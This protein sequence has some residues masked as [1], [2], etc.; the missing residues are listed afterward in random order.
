MARLVQL[1]RPFHP[2]SPRGSVAIFIIVGHPRLY[3]TWMTHDHWKA[4]EF[5][6]ANRCK[7]D[8]SLLPRWWFPRLAH[9]VSVM[10]RGKAARELFPEG[11]R[12][13]A[14]DG[15]GGPGCRIRSALSAGGH[16]SGRAPVQWW[17]LERK[18]EKG[19]LGCRRA[20]GSGWGRRAAAG[21]RVA[22]RLWC[23]LGRG[24][25]LS[26]LP[27]WGRPV[28]CLGATRPLDVALCA[29]GTR[30]FWPCV[31]PGHI[32]SGLVCPRARI[33]PA[34]SAGGVSVSQIVGG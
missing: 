28:M 11:Q 1:I 21:V 29:T 2:A 5:G 16:G 14:G 23:R 6:A 9:D 15:C 17:P 30:P 8:V 32:R 13:G 4:W 25:D 19:G 7:R 20:Q 27:P 12:P 22:G 24:W 18:A 3:L 31:P 26:V 33:V 10:A 34:S